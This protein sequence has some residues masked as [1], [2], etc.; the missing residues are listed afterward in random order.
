MKNCQQT[1]GGSL[2]LDGDRERGYRHGTISG[3][4]TVFE[5]AAK[6]LIRS[7]CNDFDVV[8]KSSLS[9]SKK[10]HMELIVEPLRLERPWQDRTTEEMRRSKTETD[11]GI[12]RSLPF[13]STGDHIHKRN[14]ENRD[15]RRAPR[16]LPQNYIRGNSTIRMMCKFIFPPSHILLSNNIS[17]HTWYIILYFKKQ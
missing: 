4:P 15:C 9:S 8:G 16:I 14:D 5:V 11:K 7:F 3:F 6:F 13:A 2:A 17:V 12:R 10:W 1:D